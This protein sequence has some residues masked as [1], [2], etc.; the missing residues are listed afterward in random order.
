M[1]IIAV[2]RRNDNIFLKSSTQ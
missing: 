1:N 2:D